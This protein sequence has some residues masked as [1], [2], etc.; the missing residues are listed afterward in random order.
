MGVCSVIVPHPGTRCL[1]ISRALIITLQTFKRHLKTFFFSLLAHSAR[2]RFFIKT[3]YLN[4]LLLLLLF[5]ILFIYYYYYYF[6]IIIIINCYYYY[7]FS[8]RQSSG[9][10][11]W[12][13]SDVSD[14][15]ECPV[16]VVFTVVQRRLA[17]FIRRT[18]STT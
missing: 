7:R 14:I 11:G 8:Q 16:E 18:V 13:V 9:S 15:N 2:L 12:L 10:S 4:S 1:T 17:A 3:R 6:I 5:F